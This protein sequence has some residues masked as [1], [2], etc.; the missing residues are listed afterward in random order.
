[1]SSQDGHRDHAELRSPRRG[2]FKRA[3]DK[4][5]TGQTITVPG[6]ATAPVG[7][8]RPLALADKLATGQRIEIPGYEADAMRAMADH[9]GFNQHFGYHVR[10]RPALRR[11][12]PRAAWRR[13][14]A[15]WFPDEIVLFHETAQA[16]R[17]RSGQ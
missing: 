17:L 1:M 14:V 9:V 11:H 4:P 5:E 10:R 15:S 16:L 13:R 2:R 3:R 12:S 6:Q 8:D 7:N